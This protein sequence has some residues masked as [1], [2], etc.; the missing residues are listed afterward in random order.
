MYI[1]FYERSCLFVEIMHALAIEKRW[2][3]HMCVSF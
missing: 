3:R 1:S 2:E